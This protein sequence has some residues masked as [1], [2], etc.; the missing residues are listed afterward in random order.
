M[1][2]AY[3]IHPVLERL[4]PDPQQRK[5]AVCRHL[6]KVNT[7][8]LM[9]P[10]LV[11]VSARL[12]RQEGES[13]ARAYRVPVMAALA[14][15]GDRIFWGHVKPLAAIAGLLGC[16]Y[17]LDSVV[18][19]VVFL[20]VYNVPHL[21]VRATGFGKGWKKGP[22]ALAGFQ[23]P[24]VE[25][26]VRLMSGLIVMGSGVVAGLVVLRAVEL[27]TGPESGRV[28]LVAAGIMVIV[29]A[30]GFWLV[31]TGLSVELAIG[32]VALTTVV[33]VLWL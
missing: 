20:L 27:V 21:F 7:H 17:W 12:E 23:S 3:C 11:G 5:D 1:G 13:A 8:P 32:A 26:A 29:S 30:A 16:L 15:H 18:G 6:E 9:G 24:R 4:Y 33:A 28:E 2:F 31:R 22:G 14:A 25:K 19:S 10:F